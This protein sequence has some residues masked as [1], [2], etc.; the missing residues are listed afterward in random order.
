MIFGVGRMTRFARFLGVALSAVLIF[1]A[2]FS[3]AAA[4]VTSVRPG[5]TDVG[6]TPHTQH[7]LPEN[8]RT[9]HEMRR[10]GFVRAQK[11]GS[12]RAAAEKK[13]ANRAALSSLQERRLAEISRTG[14]FFS[15]ILRAWR[16]F[17]SSLRTP[18][19]YFVLSDGV[20]SGLTPE[21]ELH[22]K[23]VHELTVPDGVRKIGKNV[24]KS[25][26]LRKI[27]LPQSVKEIDDYA[28]YDNK[29]SEVS[30]SHV[31][32]IGRSAFQK[33]AVAGKLELKNLQLLGLSLIHI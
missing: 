12:V 7:S 14:G 18:G 1:P 25:R 26:G 3:P 13:T 28:F 19:G 8:P 9:A 20:L 4:A 27:S 32:K 16:G 33:N 10:T 31:S 24:F 6:L 15:G 23:T 30:L 5:Y 22:F 29:I 17:S 11:S 2:G 21:G